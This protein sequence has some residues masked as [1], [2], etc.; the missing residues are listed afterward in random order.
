MW[1]MSITGWM[2]HVHHLAKRRGLHA[3]GLVPDEFHVPQ[4]RTR[5][6]Q[7]SGA[8][9]FSARLPG[10]LGKLMFSERGLLEPGAGP[11]HCLFWNSLEKQRGSFTCNDYFP[12]PEGN[13]S[14]MGHLFHL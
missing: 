12:G 3:H 9:E 5:R 13:R 7:G 10:E 1:R 11:Q 2:S 6:Q 14:Q 4:I 8:T